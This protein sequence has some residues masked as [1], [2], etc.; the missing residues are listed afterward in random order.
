MRNWRIAGK[1]RKNG[2]SPQ[3]DH[4][5]EESVDKLRVTG[6]DVENSNR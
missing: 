1:I 3:G 5:V 4:K 2:L 6:E